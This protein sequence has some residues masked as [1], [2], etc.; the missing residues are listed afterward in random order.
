M[1]TKTTTLAPHR[2]FIIEVKED[3]EI[4]SQQIWRQTS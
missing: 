1:T 2:K 4:Q 3:E